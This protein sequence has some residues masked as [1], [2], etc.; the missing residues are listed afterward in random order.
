[1]SCVIVALTLPLLVRSPNTLFTC[2]SLLLQTVVADGRLEHFGMRWKGRY[3]R[4]SPDRAITIAAA[5]QSDVAP[6]LLDDSC[7]PGTDSPLHS[8]S[9]VKSLN[10]AS[11]IRPASPTRTSPLDSRASNKSY[12]LRSPSTGVR[13]I[14]DLRTMPT[15]MRTA[16]TTTE[17]RRAMKKIW[18]EG[19]M[20]AVTGLGP[21]LLVA[22][23]LQRC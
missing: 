19:S 3:M 9:P 23:L 14:L 20:T 16:S 18:L 5:S 11:R 21:V 15:A 1:M 6:C 2:K 8:A 13:P 7:R 12:R 10:F 4:V 17:R 22:W